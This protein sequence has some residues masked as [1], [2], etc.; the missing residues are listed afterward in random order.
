MIFCT[1][2]TFDLFLRFRS[3][4]RLGIHP[5]VFC[6]VSRNNI[7]MGR[8]M[9]S[10]LPSKVKISVFFPM[11]L[12]TTICNMRYCFF[13][14]F[15]WRSLHLDYRKTSK[16]A[17]NVYFWPKYLHWGL[18]EFNCGTFTPH[19]PPMYGKHRKKL[20]WPNEK[21]NK[22]PFLH[23]QYQTPLAIIPWLWAKILKGIKAS[24]L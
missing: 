10:I 8:I 19:N 22:F 4:Y 21:I 23:D 13:S 15:Y 3:N 12:P 16:F 18:W 2:L 17:G 24:Q 6:H 14:S 1:Q 20:A 11:G 9:S 5:Y 7:S